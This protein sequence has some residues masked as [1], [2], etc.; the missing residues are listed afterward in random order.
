MAIPFVAIFAALP[1]ALFVQWL[2]EGKPTYRKLLPL[3]GALAMGLL[4]LVDLNYYFR[5]IYPAYVLGGGNTVAATAIAEDLRGQ[6]PADV[7]FL[8]FPRM[9]Y[10]SLST[11]PYLAPQMRGTDLIE[12]L[13]E[14]ADI[15]LTGP[16]LFVFLP[17]RLGELLFVEQSYPGGRYREVSGPDGTLLYAVY[18]LRS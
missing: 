9:G 3:A 18:E 4:M 1:I 17:E 16:S 7:Y 12:P 11:I 14:P 8:G 15:P 13:T 10:F 6:E 5:Q 2:S